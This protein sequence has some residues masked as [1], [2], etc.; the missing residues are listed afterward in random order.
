MWHIGN[1]NNFGLIANYMIVTNFI[2]FGFE[3]EQELY[4]FYMKLL[5]GT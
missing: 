2:I 3:T 5:L 1:I 4:T